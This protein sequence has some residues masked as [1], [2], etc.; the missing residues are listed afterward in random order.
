MK[1]HSGWDDAIKEAVFR[2][3]ADR[4]KT[5]FVKGCQLKQAADLCDW[6]VEGTTGTAKDGHVAYVHTMLLAMATEALLK[7]AF[8]LRKGTPLVP[9]KK[10][11]LKLDDDF[12]THDLRELAGMV[13]FPAAATELALLDRLTLFVMWFAR[14]PVPIESNFA[15]QVGV[16]SD[17]R[18]AAL[19]F[20]QRLHDSLVSEPTLN[21]LAKP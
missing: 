12:K 8:V 2:N 1:T 19:A 15:Q 11:G 7:A 10:G 5:W 3:R 9:R 20:Y 21:D 6:I 4:P 16:T 18:L 14:Y 13:R 17:E